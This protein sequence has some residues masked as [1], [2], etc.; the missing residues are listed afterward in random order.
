MI[1]VVFGASTSIVEDVVAV[2]GCA[3]KWFASGDLLLE[4][5][6]SVTDSPPKLDLQIQN[7]MSQFVRHPKD[8]IPPWISLEDLAKNCHEL[9]EGID[10]HLWQPQSTLPPLQQLVDLHDGHEVIILVELFAR[11]G[12]G[13]PAALEAGLS[14]Q[15]YTYVD[16][17]VV[18]RRAAK[19]H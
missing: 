15:S 6:M 13:L 7:K 18:V 2:Y 1:P 17:N 11:F 12:T 19:H 14:I 4:G 10:Q 3:A 8:P 5:N 16:N 9:V